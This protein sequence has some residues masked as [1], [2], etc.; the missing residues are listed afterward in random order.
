MDV[1]AL[2]RLMFL[3]GLVLLI[4]TVAAARRTHSES[5]GTQLAL[6]GGIA[7]GAFFF[8]AG[9]AGILTEQPRPAVDLETEPAPKFEGR[10][11]NAGVVI[12][13]YVAVLAVI[14]GIAA[15]VGFGD[16]GYGIQAFT[17]AVILGGM[18]FGLGY[19][20]G[21]HPIDIEQ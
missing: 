11:P 14:A 2:R 1:R 20:L 7:L 19:M 5:T 6:I 18:V 3:V 10:R 16:A 21:H 17:F 4:V 8:I 9:L 13:L 12:G 15:G